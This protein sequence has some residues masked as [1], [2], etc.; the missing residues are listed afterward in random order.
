MAGINFR[1]PYLTEEKEESEKLSRNNSMNE[2]KDSGFV[3]EDD[4]AENFDMVE[5]ENEDDVDEIAEKW[6]ED[7]GVSQDVTISSSFF[8]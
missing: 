6:L 8:G 2:E 7:L 3:G 5:A 4:N 1:T